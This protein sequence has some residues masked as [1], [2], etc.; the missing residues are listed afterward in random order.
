M[1]INQHE[2]YEYARLRIKQK[3]RLYVHFMIWF[4]ASLFLLF[5]HYILNTFPDS[6]WSLWV[7]MIWFF[8]FVLHF[9]R[10]F[11]TERFMNKKWEREQIEKLV[12][13]QQRKLEQLQKDIQKNA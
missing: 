2:L 11:I 9:I 1:D 6:N 7:V 5:A 10:V 8:F 4:T 12:F 3:K 13:K